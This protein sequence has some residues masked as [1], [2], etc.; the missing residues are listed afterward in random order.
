MSY[1]DYTFPVRNCRVT[2]SALNYPCIR[3][4][5]TFNL[6]SLAHDIYH[7]LVVHELREQYVQEVLAVSRVRK[8]QREKFSFRRIDYI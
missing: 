2:A 1:K 6:H 3:Q 5:L 8:I 7:S 4:A